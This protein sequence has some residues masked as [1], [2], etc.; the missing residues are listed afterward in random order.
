CY[1]LSWVGLQG[2]IALYL[3]S[4]IAILRSTHYYINCSNHLQSI[5]SHLDLEDYC[6]IGRASCSERVQFNVLDAIHSSN[7]ITSYSIIA[8]LQYYLRNNGPLQLIQ[9]N[10]DL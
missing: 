3:H 1:D 4:N 2:H 9:S 5:L 7:T 8:V 10:L 6:Q